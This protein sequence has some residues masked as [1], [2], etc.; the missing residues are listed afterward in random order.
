VTGPRPTHPGSTEKTRRHG[1]DTQIIF[2]YLCYKLTKVCE[3]FF[4]TGTE[5][6]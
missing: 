5:V 3:K 4:F 2:F 1:T 6:A